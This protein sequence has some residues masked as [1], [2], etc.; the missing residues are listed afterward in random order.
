MSKQE[1]EFEKKYACTDPDGLTI[2]LLIMGFQKVS[3]GEETDT[4]FSD[5]AGNFIR[6]N[7]CLR[8][9]K[10]A[11]GAARLDFKGASDDPTAQFIAKLE[12]N[13]SLEAGSVDQLVRII[14]L[15]GFVKH[16]EVRKFRRAYAGQFLGQ[17]VNIYLDR[18]NEG[19]EYCEVE[20]T[21]KDGASKKEMAT[22]LE[23][24]SECLSAFLGSI[25][26]EPYRE[27]V[28]AF[29]LRKLLSEDLEFVVKGKN[30]QRIFLL[31]LSAEKYHSSRS[32]DAA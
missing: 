25:E 13:A 26:T 8:L 18:L 9:R 23:R 31:M 22:V 21:A 4:Y 24:L 17:N 3:I 14:E 11:D 16:I 20:I 29:Q 5:L 10:K 32:F 28:C 2:E 27:I 30:A 1:Y 12:H 7:I 15:L 19:I 6:K